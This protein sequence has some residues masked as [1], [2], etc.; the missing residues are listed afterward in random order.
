M[1]EKLSNVKRAL[2]AQEYQAMGFPCRR[3]A[4]NYLARLGWSHG[5]ERIF[6]RRHKAAGLVR[7]GRYPAKAPRSSIC[8]SWKTSVGQHIFRA[9]MLHCGTRFEAYLTGR[10]VARAH[11][12]Q[13]DGLERAMY[14]LKGTREEI[15]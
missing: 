14:C 10:P 4:A 8:K 13:A 2:G 7:S 6:N 3:Y 5:N 11:V 15:P 12:S 9:M 1:G